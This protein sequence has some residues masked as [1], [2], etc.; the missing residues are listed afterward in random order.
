MKKYY[1]KSM[2]G[3]LVAT[4]TMFTLSLTSCQ[5]DEIADGARYTFTGHTVASYLEEHEETFSHFINIL[6]RGNRYN[7]MQA[8]G[9]YTCFAPTNEAVEK[10]VEQQYAIYDSTVI[11]D[12]LDTIVDITTGIYSPYVEDLFN[13]SQRSDSM[14][15]VI[16]Q[17]H[18]VDKAYLTTEFATDV[19]PE[20]NFN[21]RY[22]SVA[23]REN[24]KGKPAIYIN[25]TAEIVVLD[26]EVE[27]GVVHTVSSVINPSSNTLNTQIG[28]NKMFSLFYSALKRTGIENMIVNHEN[29][30]YNMQNEQVV[31][32]KL[33]RTSEKNF[34][35]YP[36]SHYY[37][38]SA[39][40][41]P[42]EVFEEMGITS[43][44]D[45]ERQ[46]RLWYPEAKSDDPTDPDNA[47]YQFVAYHFINQKIQYSRLVCYDISITDFKSETNFGRNT[48]RIEYYETL[49]NKLI[50]VTRPLHHPTDRSDIWLNYIDSTDIEYTNIVVREPSALKADELFADFDQNALNGVI[51]VIDKPLVYNEETMKSF[52]LNCIMRFDFSSLVPELRNNDMRWSARGD[53]GTSGGGINFYMPTNGYCSTIKFINAETNLFYLC[54]TVSWRNY[55]GDEFIA[56]GA[57]DF[58]YK[59][60]PVPAGTY[61]IRF[62]YSAN[63]NRGICQFYVDGDVTGIP[64]DLRMGAKDDRIGYVDDDAKDVTVGI[65][66]DKEMKNRGYLKGPTTYNVSNS[67]NSA[68][69]TEY[70]IRKVIT[71]KYLTEGDHWLRFKNAMEGDKD[72]ELMHDYLEL[73]PIGYLRNPD[74]SYTEKRK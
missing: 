72:S 44:E 61:E 22:L 12:V 64:V 37:G 51:H 60:P 45:L 21:N 20:A 2:V 24:E 8:Y 66:N 47:L 56:S 31:G 59:L 70:C 68:R 41:E 7:L 39:F 32:E 58:A 42:N 23:H 52:V 4:M 11:K 5:D 71:T 57:F 63:S 16:A 28:V 35:P 62:G 53:A 15:K 43:I 9:T 38:Y 3:V 33:Y 67:T 29:Y 6:K 19:V 36:P 49:N 73:I 65:N 30:D 74:I 50:K 54:P 34:S 1:Y 13:E 27:N 10:F 18:L 48:D 40:I 46:C 14:C 25:N 26:E 17:T 55:Q 69:T